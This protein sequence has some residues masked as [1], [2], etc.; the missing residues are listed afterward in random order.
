MTRLVVT[1]QAD[2]DAIDILAYLHR[3]AGLRVTENCGHTC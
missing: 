3:E 2:A 1:P